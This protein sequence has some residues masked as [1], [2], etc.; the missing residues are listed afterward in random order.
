MILL[1]SFP[2]QSKTPQAE[3]HDMTPDQEYMLSSSVI[4]VFVL[5]TFFR[6]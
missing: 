3:G 2:D 6:N 1:F 5:N 4:P